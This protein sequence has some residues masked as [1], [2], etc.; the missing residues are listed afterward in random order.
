[1]KLPQK[2]EAGYFKL[3]FGQKGNLS[4]LAE[5]KGLGSNKEIIKKNVQRKSDETDKINNKS[6]FSEINLKRYNTLD[7]NLN[8]NN[9]TGPDLFVSNVIDS[10]CDQQIVCEKIQEKPSYDEEIDSVGE[11]KSI[12]ETEFKGCADKK[13]SR[14]LTEISVK[15]PE[16]VKIDDISE[17]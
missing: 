9:N 2:E 1:M 6:C 8:F 13:Y 14:L 15:I 4:D 12:S 10:E 17:E 16:M 3:S 11:Y 7:Q 5:K